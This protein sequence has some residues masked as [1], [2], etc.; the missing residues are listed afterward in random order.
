MTDKRMKV[1]KIKCKWG[2]NRDDSATKQSAIYLLEYILGISV[3][4]AQTFLLAKRP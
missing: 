3:A 1:T 2:R 4:R